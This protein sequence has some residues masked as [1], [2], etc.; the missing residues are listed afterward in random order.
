MVRGLNTVIRDWEIEDYI[1][2]CHITLGLVCFS[3]YLNVDT[4]I[5]LWT[6]I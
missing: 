1:S 3:L 5:K 4:N 2:N 6:A